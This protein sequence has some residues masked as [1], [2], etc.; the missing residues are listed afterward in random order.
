M[1]I[2]FLIA[3]FVLIGTNCSESPTVA[4]PT[5][6]NVTASVTGAVE[7]EYAGTGIVTTRIFEGWYTLQLPSSGK[8]SNTRYSMGIYIFYVGGQEKSG[9]FPFVENPTTLNEDHAFA[10]FEIGESN[11]K[12]F[13]SISGSVKIDTIVGTGVAGSFSFVARD[14]TTGDTV[15]VSNGRIRF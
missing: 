4:P 11:R 1:K 12:I 9:T 7:I 2:L 5:N 10:T 3:I 14:S 6:P 8:I 13:K 15:V